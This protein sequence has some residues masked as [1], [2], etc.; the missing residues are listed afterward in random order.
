LPWIIADA[1]G[2]RITGSPKKAAVF[3]E[4]GP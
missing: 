2:E 1:P 3:D 4:E